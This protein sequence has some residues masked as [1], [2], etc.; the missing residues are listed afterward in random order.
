[1]FGVL[2][3]SPGLLPYPPQ[4]LDFGFLFAKKPKLK[5]SNHHAQVKHTH[6]NETSIDEAQAIAFSSQIDHGF[7]LPEIETPDSRLMSNT[8]FEQDRISSG[9]TSEGYCPIRFARY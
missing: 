6:I 7:I 4:G 1:M 9:Q 3:K 2:S 5:P 8:M